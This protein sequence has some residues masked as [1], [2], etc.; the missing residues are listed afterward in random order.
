[1]RNVH[2]RTEFIGGLSWIFYICILILLQFICFVVIYIL[3]DIWIFGPSRIR[4]DK[5]YNNWSHWNIV[6]LMRDNWI[7][8]FLLPKDVVEFFLNHTRELYW[9]RQSSN[10]YSVS[11]WH[12]YQCHRD[13]TPSFNLNNIEGHSVA[14][15]LGLLRE[16]KTLAKLKKY[17]VCYGKNYSKL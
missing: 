16:S 12:L 13:R 8:P 15:S 11:L 5:K 4:K 10:Y 9:D 14:E 17:Q 2:E 6:P 1:M 3:Y 7:G